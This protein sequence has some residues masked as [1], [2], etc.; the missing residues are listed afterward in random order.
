MATWEFPGSEPIEMVIE[1]ASGSV[2]V[3]GEPGPATTVTVHS[4]R[5]GDDD[6]LPPEELQ[7]SFTAGRLEIIQ[8]KSSS[9]LRGHATLDVTVQAPAGSRGTLRTA[10]ADVSCVG[11]LA[12]LEA[13]TASGD[14]T[15]AS[16]RGAAAINTAS[17]DVWLEQAGGAVAIR[18]ASG[19][20]R[21]RRAGAD[22]AVVTA[23]GDARIGEVAGSVT[24]QTASGDVAIGSVT[25]GETNVKTATG[26]VSVGVARG[27]EVYLDLAS[28][29]GSIHSQLEEAA[30]GE[31]IALRVTCRSI[32][33]DIQISR[34][35]ATADAQ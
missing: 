33:G 11:D 9:W 7:V 25:A 13:R 22:A 16:V 32:S 1:I 14:V 23:S 34:A 21:L 2:A 20:V 29:T 8:P 26:D 10:S 30:A 3:S 31:G 12:E 18:T 6:P 27:A 4:S 5:H 15:V 35:A 24:A 19:D 28:L 17:G